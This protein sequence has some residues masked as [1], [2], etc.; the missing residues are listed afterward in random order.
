MKNR[1]KTCGW[2]FE[3]TSVQIHRRIT[4]GYLPICQSCSRIAKAEKSAEK[5][6]IRKNRTVEEM[7]VSKL[8]PY[9][10]KYGKVSVTFVQRKFKID[11]EIAE[12]ISEKINE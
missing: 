6:T 4:K 10:M 8:Y 1:C 11:F 2:E 7:Y 5:R 3:E 9:K 12:K